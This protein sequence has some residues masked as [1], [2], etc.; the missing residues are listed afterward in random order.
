MQTIQLEKSS[1][2]VEEIR[3]ELEHSRREEGRLKSENGSLQVQLEVLDK[4]RR[5]KDQ[6]H[7]EEVMP[8]SLFGIL[9]LLF[10]FPRAFCCLPRW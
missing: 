9:C 7:Y 5:V 1:C 2:L 3:S 6:E 8:N 10:N 4:Q